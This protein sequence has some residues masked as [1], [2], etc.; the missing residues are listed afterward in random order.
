MISK[1][2][3]QA[4]PTKR[5]PI[6]TTPVR[7]VW[8]RKGDR[9]IAGK[10]SIVHKSDPEFPELALRSDLGPIDVWSYDTSGKKPRYTLQAILLKIKAQA[11]RDANKRA[12]LSAKA[13][14]RAARIKKA[15][16]LLDA[17]S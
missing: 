2:K 4:A 16:A 17:Q 7:L 14:A 12:T 8:R 11:E 1:N 3:K 10:Y 13:K 15:L 9:W 5:E 6:P